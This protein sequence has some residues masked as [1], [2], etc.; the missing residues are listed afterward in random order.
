MAAVLDG[1]RVLDF[2]RYVAGPV[3]ATLLGDLG[4]EVI[5]IERPEGGEDR[6]LCPIGSD[7]GGALFL[8]TGRNKS[9]IT[10]SL[11]SEEAKPILER[12][13]KSADVVVANMPLSILKKVGLDY[14]SLKAIKE[15]IILTTPS[16]Y[17]ENGPYSKKVGFDGVAQ[18]MSGTMYLSGEGTPTKASA[19]YVDYAT[20]CLS[21]FA[22]LAAIH[23][24]KKSGQ[25]QHVETSLLSS[26]LMV[27]NVAITEQAELN[28]NR[29]PIG[30][31]T[32]YAAPADTFQSKDGWV[33]VQAIGPYMFKRWCTL[34]GKPEFLED[35]RFKDDDSRGVH[36]FYLSEVMQAWCSQFTSKEL[37]A[38]LEANRLPCA[39]VLTPQ[40][41]LEDEHVVATEQLVD[42]E[43]PGLKSPAKIVAP[44]FKLSET[45]AK[46]VGR[47][48]L[49][50]EH[51]DKILAKLGFSDVELKDFRE[52]KAI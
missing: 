17:G 43:F 42:M 47:A 51:T 21:A 38:K 20:A 33:I 44:P 3:C 31:R 48:P 25:G 14:E 15:N 4:A 46:T 8:T 7:E 9:G 27:G 23:E 11:G 6:E 32:Q 37:V 26:A 36:G 35:E 2:G 52:N 1:I 24:L 10:L 41:A 28:I 49:L 30:N 50:G 45:P 12:L 19:P 13:V 22:T 34:V 29:K 39:E 18:A 5:R 16:A 40:Q